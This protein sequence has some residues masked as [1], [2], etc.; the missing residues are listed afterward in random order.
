MSEKMT[1]EEKLKIYRMFILQMR[2]HLNEGYLKMSSCRIMDTIML[3]RL[4]EDAE[5]AKNGVEEKEINTRIIE[6]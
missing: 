1:P 6:T 2:D 4:I 3:E 5:A